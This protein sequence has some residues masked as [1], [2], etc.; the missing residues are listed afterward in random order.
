MGGFLVVLLWLLAGIIA[1]WI[2]GELD[3][4]R[5]KDKR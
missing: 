5:W 4:Q 2:F 3:L 1:T